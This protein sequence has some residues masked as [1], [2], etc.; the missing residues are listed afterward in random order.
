[1]FDILDDPHRRHLLLTLLVGLGLGA[2]LTGSIESIYGFDL[3][4]LLTLGGG[5]PI[6]LA[7]V[8]ALRQGK[9]SA[10]LA[11]SLAAFAALFL[12]FVERDPTMY[13]VAAEVIFIMLI[14]EALEHFAVGRTRTGIAALLALR[15]HEARVRRRMKYEPGH[16]HEHDHGDEHDHEHHHEHELVV[17][18]D[19]IRP[20]DVVIVRPGDRIPVD[21]RVLSGTS[22]V[23]Q[24]PITGESLPADKVV[25]DEV[26]AGTINLY[27]ALELSVERLG[28]DTTLEQ[29]IHLVEEAEAAKAPTQRLADRYAGW[30]VPIVFVTAVLTWL[31]SGETWFGSDGVVR[32]VAVLVVACPCALV[33]ATPTAIAAGI[34]ALV[35]RGVLIKGGVALEK[36]GRLRSV[37]FDKTGTLTLARLQIAEIVPAPGHD[38]TEVLRLGASVERQS[39]HP[40]GQ[41]IVRRA[42][43]EAVELAEAADFVAHPGLGAE[44]RVAGATVRVGSPRFLSETGI[45]LP[46][47]LQAEVARLSG[48]G[49]TVVLVARDG[50]TV[51]AVAVS[52]TA[53]PEAKPTVGRLRGLGIQRIVMLTGDNEAAARSVA[54]ALG[55][56]EARAGLL[57]NDKVEA[58]REI[59]RAAAPVAMVGDGINDAPSLVAADVGVAM[60]DIGSDVAIAS[61]DVVL[62]GDDLG[63]LADA[64]TTSRRML[65]IIW[66]NILGF[67]LVFNAVT[68]AAASLGWISPVAAAVVHQVSSLAVVLN[69]LRLLVDV[70]SCRA[71]F[72]GLCERLHRRRRILLAGA[73]TV[74]VAGYLL[75]GLH[76]VRMGEIA[77]VQHFG[78]IVRPEEPPGLHYRLPW[79]FGRHRRVRPAEVR[80]VEVGFRTIPGS[81]E[82]PPAYE[83]NVQH[84]GGRSERQA[85]E[86]TVLTGDENLADVN[87]VVQYRVSDPTAALMRVGEFTS[88]GTSK[89]DAVVR[90][91]AEA[92]LREVMSRR[93]IDSVLSDE[94]SEIEEEIGR[95][96]A[97][98][99]EAYDA[100]FSVESVCL[101]DVHPP[102]E[103]VSEFR[104]VVKAREEK[105]AKINQAE[106][107]QYER[108]A[109]A[110]GKSEQ[111]VLAAEASGADRTHKSRGR[112]DRF[113]AVARACSQHPELTRLRLYLEMVERALAGRKK[114]IV[115][116]VPDGARRQ[117]FLGRT[118]LLGALPRTPSEETQE[119]VQP[120]EY[121]QP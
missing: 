18:V 72:D 121:P 104:E 83:W 23:D 2:Y 80:R 31:F 5:F 43:E 9:L 75:S 53:R 45:A 36:L 96:I 24:S 106:A 46:P 52:D 109:L 86:A 85:E 55:I 15:P 90:A 89:W 116:R 56:E 74:V 1:M 42:V 33:L 103:V 98:V 69:S 50:A 30:F 59:Q 28:E 10:D 107:Y 8:V 19:E 91:V 66:Q 108:Q 117:L 47:E 40:V 73:A 38:F 57:P 67:A 37:V 11:V 102:F 22:S 99:L 93:S 3:A 100:G 113:A 13:A 39:E 92:G 12:G 84:R 54:E 21:G 94:R 25:G 115:D 29:I 48:A 26:F 111:T 70:Q 77:V 65:R 82:E 114:V 118:G 6:H 110:R 76:V 95:R 58:V 41:L 64:V 88:G 14:G 61:A 101:G 20:D 51:G 49:C 34:G 16:G 62:V 32:A 71:W 79:P 112:A 35:R 17:P 4:V 7:A 63:K 81:F 120:E 68:V 27:G 97:A 78:K 60:A 44:A 87:L 119:I 105:E